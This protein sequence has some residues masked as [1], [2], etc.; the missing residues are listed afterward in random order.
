MDSRLAKSIAV[1]G[2]R[3][4]KYLEAYQGTG[5]D[6]KERVLQRRQQTLQKFGAVWGSS[7]ASHFLTK[8][9]DA[10]SLIWAF[11]S[12]NLELFIEKF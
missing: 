2:L 4:Q 7:M 5:D 3:L 8:Y 12:D 10:E 9:N 11:D 1:K 6:D